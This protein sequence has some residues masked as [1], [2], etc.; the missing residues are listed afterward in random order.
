MRSKYVE[1]TLATGEAIV[2]ETR[3]HWI[4]FGWRACFI[5]LLLIALPHESNE[6][7]VAYLSKLLLFLVIFSPIFL[8]PLITYRT[9]EFAVTNKRLII[10]V[11]WLSR[12]TLELSLNKV[13]SAA[14]SQ[15]FLG[16][17]LD[18]G[19]I[20]FIGT[21]GTHQLF[22]T[23]AKPHDLKSAVLRSQANTE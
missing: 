21:G 4:Y 3:L 1:S 2:Y 7:T 15:S 16:R 6:N 18:Y 5:V 23:V 19:S 10:K 17:M 9:S 20:T 22:K 11:G 8:F 13:E 14:I 12:R